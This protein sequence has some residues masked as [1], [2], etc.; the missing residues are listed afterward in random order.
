MDFVIGCL[1]CYSGCGANGMKVNPCSSNCRWKMSPKDTS[2]AL[3]AARIPVCLDKGH[4]DGNQRELDVLTMRDWRRG[5]THLVRE[6][7]GNF[8]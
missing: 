6:S 3:M 1:Q 2:V 7:K 8:G 4:G 5:S